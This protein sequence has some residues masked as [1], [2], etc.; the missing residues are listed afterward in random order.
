M[1]SVVL[2]RM[3]WVDY[4]IGIEELMRWWNSDIREHEHP[5]GSLAESHTGWHIGISILIMMQVY[6][7]E[8]TPAKAIGNAWLREFWGRRGGPEY[9]WILK[10]GPGCND[11]EL[12]DLG[13]VQSFN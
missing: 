4:E 2:I 13:I 9:Y 8:L 5:A 3:F 7:I 6:R 11:L 1:Q 10:K 12:K